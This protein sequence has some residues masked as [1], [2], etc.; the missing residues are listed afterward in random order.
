M[1]S[2]KATSRAN[3]SALARTTTRAPIAKRSIGVPSCPI[4]VIKMP[5][6][7]Q[8]VLGNIGVNVK[9]DI[10]CQRRRINV[11]LSTYASR[12]LF[13]AQCT[14]SVAILARVP[15]NANASRDILA[16]L[17]NPS[18]LAR[19]SHA[20]SMEYARGPALALSNALVRRV[21][22]SQ[23]VN[24]LAMPSILAPKLPNAIRMLYA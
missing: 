21:M 22:S 24:K 5:T 6:V 14:L 3:S 19:R 10:G 4:L 2:A 11:S 9:L 1:Q 17:A 7:S 15:T 23:L 12:S 13:L 8:L 16:L 20:P 18:M